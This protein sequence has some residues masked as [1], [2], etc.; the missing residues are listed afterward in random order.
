M[1]LKGPKFRAALKIQ[2]SVTVLHIN[3]HIDIQIQTV[4]VHEKII[5]SVRVLCTRIIRLNLKDSTTLVI[6]AVIIDT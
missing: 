5:G 6:I 3:T 2:N 1:V 4:L